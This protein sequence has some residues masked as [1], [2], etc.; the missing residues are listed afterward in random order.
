MRGNLE[1]LWYK[2]YRKISK[3]FKQLAFGVGWERK[4]DESNG[5]ITQLGEE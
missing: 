3:R 4:G 1:L 5:K 2:R